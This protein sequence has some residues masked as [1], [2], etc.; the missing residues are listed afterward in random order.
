MGLPMGL[1]PQHRAGAHPLGQAVKLPR[2][3]ILAAVGGHGGPHGVKGAGQK[4]IY[5]KR[6]NPTASLE[7][8]SR[9]MTKIKPIKPAKA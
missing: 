6:R 1:H 5:L 3:R 7:T 4:L 2:A 9:A 8:I